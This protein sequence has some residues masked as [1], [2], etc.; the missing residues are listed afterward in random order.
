MTPRLH[1]VAAN[2]YLLADRQEAALP[3]FRRLL[4]LSSNYD[5]A[6]FRLCLDAY[7]DPMM[8]LDK[9]V[10]D[11][12]NLMTKLDYVNF[13]SA[14]GEADVAYRA[15]G[16]VVAGAAPFPWAEAEPSSSACSSWADT[17]RRPA[18]GRTSSVWVW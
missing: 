13:L 5:W 2:S 10:P 12:P 6:V 11:G 17:A 16:R 18:S 9:I 8:V 1:W 14:Q 4:E 15:W 3:Q 7:G